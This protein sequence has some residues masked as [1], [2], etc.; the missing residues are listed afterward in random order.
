MTTQERDPEF[1]QLLEFLRDERGFDFT[2]YKRPSLMRRITKRMQEADLHG[3]YGV[4]RDY[5]GQHPE[6]FAQLFDTILINVTS[7]FRDAPAWDFL[8]QEIVPRII[9][10]RTPNDPLRLW[11]TGCSTGEEAYTLAMVFAEALGTEDFRSR[12]KIYAT[13]VDEGALGTGRTAT[14]TPAQLEP[15]PEN[16]RERYFEQANGDGFSFRADLRRAVIFGRHDLVQDPPIS[17]IDLLV[18]RN[19]L[20]YFDTDTQQ[21]IL[22]SFHYALRDEGYLFLGK[23]EVLIARSPLF[24][25]V[26]LKRRVFAKARGE[27]VGGQPYQRGGWAADRVPPPDDLA[28]LTFELAPVAQLVVDR[29]GTLALANR[30]A[31]TL[32]GLG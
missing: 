15:V 20:M 1:E 22:F 31:C 30:H 11:S 12:V 29:T 28:D 5:L 26:D 8:A 23:S 21:R 32:F 13:D 14:Y 18:S 27:R 24:S 6:E 17:R 10:L 7:F 9:E 19:T 2:G 16:L 25:A 4:Y 3:D